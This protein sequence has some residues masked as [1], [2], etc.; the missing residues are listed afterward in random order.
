MMF[1]MGY[2]HS[3][4]GRSY[5]ASAGHGFETHYV[6][7]PRSHY[8]RDIACNSMHMPLK[9]CTIDPSHHCEVY[10]LVSRDIYAHGEKN[11]KSNIGTT[12]ASARPQTHA[13]T[14]GTACCRRRFFYISRQQCGGCGSPCYCREN[15]QYSQ[16]L[17]WEVMVISSSGFHSQGYSPRTCY[18][19][20][21]G[22]HEVIGT[23]RCRHV[24]FFSWEKMKTRNQ[25]GLVIIY[26]L[27]NIYIPRQELSDN[28]PSRWWGKLMMCFEAGP[29]LTNNCYTIRQKEKYIRR[30]GCRILYNIFMKGSTRTQNNKRKKILY[31]RFQCI[32][33]TTYYS[34]CVPKVSSFKQL[35]L[36]TRWCLVLKW[37]VKYVVFFSCCL[38]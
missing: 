18:L 4:S 15:V 36:R 31:Q 13:K 22:S 10:T 33:N 27:Y 35:Y 37:I 12:S 16:W 38:I 2:R 26:I 1:G 25:K 19:P 8:K 23:L 34:L 5:A 6:I 7:S 21:A 20:L 30:G 3:P 32:N 11:M 29:S 28:T 24:V 9:R 17:D 14:D